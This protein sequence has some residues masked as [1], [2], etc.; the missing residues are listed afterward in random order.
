MKY[1]K[2]FENKSNELDFLKQIQNLIKDEG[3]EPTLV[4]IKSYQGG[5]VKYTHKLEIRELKYQRL[6]TNS[7]KDNEDFFELCLNVQ[8]RLESFGIFQEI[9]NHKPKK[10]LL[11]RMNPFVW[12]NGYHHVKKEFNIKEIKD[13]EIL[14]IVFNLNI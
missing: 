8:K 3:Y 4:E 2:Y 10:G 14:S 1:L 9:K 12:I 7:I 6:Y 13:S 5:A 11:P